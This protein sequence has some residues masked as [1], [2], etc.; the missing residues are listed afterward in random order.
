VTIDRAALERAWVH[1][2]EED[3]ASEQVFRPAAFAFPPSRGRRGF[4]LRPD[5]SYVETAPGPTDR[6]EEASGTW[7]LDDDTLVLS[8]SDGRGSE[9]MRVTAV[10]AERLVLAR[11]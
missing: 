5:G 9:R 2:H 11:G 7:E 10:D 1:S 6:P 8:P 3:T 4:E